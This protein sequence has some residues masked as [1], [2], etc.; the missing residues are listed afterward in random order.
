MNKTLVVA[1][2]LTTGL[3]LQA[4]NVISFNYDAYAAVS[5]AAATAGVV[6]A[7]NWNDSYLIDGNAGNGNSTYSSLLDNSGAAT[8]LSL[9]TAAFGVYQIQGSDPGLDGDGTYNRRMLNGYINA[10]GTV[11]PTTTSFALSSI[12]YSVYDIYVYFTSDTANRTGTV[13]DGTTTYDFS[14]MG[15]AEISGANALFTQTI[16]TGGSNPLADY[17]VFSGLSGASQTITADI[18][19]FGGLAGIQIVAVPEP[20]TEALAGLGGLAMLVL[21]RRK[22]KAAFH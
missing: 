14:T 22:T 2:L 17:A 9:T 6:P 11:T 3:G 19:N 21:V 12:P 4:Q 15:P 1:A 13:S 16:D 20:A 5:G 18:P 7:A 8:T 10:G